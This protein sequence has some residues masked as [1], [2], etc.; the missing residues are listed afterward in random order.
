MLSLLFPEICKFPYAA[1]VAFA[2]GGDAVGHPVFFALDLLRKFVLV[3][4][5]LLEDLVAPGFKMREAL[6]K[7]ACAAAVNPDRGP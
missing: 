6:F 2:T 1:H 4:L 3:D 5:F 7:A